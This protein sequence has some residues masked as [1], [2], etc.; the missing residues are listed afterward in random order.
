MTERGGQ[1]EWNIEKV[2]ENLSYLQSLVEGLPEPLKKNELKKINKILN[3]NKN[4]AMFYCKLYNHFVEKK[5]TNAIPLYRLCKSIQCK[6]GHIAYFLELLVDMGLAEKKKSPDKK[7]GVY[8]VL[9][10]TDKYMETHIHI[11]MNL[12]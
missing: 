9:K 7:K 8:I 12:R 4:A 3:K 2:Y 11:M 5:A 1:K 6:I 10:D